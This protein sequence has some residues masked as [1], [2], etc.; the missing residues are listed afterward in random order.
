[1]PPKPRPTT[2]T[3]VCTRCQVEKPAKM[4]RKKSRR[5][6]ACE[7]ALTQERQTRDKP[8]M[9]TYAK[10]RRTMF[11]EQH[12]N[13]ELL[14]ADGK[15]AWLCPRCQTN[16]PLSDFGRNANTASGLQPYC[17]MCMAEAARKSHWKHREIYV[18]KMREDYAANR[19]ESIAYTRAWQKAHPDE[20]RSTWAVRRARKREAFIE[21]VD[22]A[23]LYE[24]D[25]GICQHCHNRIAKKQGNIN[26]IIPLAL[27]GL[28]SY[29]NT[30]LLC[31]ACNF[32]K[33]AS[34]TGDQTRLF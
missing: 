31:Q 22:Y 34:G 7:S 5:C 24:R 33:G 28:H 27:G 12:A 20:M 17:K 8:R 3:L 9:L 21:K 19:I 11:Q 13:E 18:A 29:K 10:Q 1:M 23:V 2:P 16:K 15:N 30:Q 26:H 4:F 14:L 25:S 6:R 32:K